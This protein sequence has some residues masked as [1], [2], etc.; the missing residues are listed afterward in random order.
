[1]K[2][3]L[4][5]FFSLCALVYAQNV[6]EISRQADEHMLQGE[7]TAAAELLEKGI[8]D[9]PDSADLLATYGMCLSKQA[10]S[11]TMMKAGML[12]EKAFKQFDAAL[13]LA[14]EHMNATLYRGILSIQVPSFMGKLH[15]GIRDLE[16]IRSKYGANPALYV[17]SN[18]YLGIGYQKNEEPAKAV[19]AFH[20]IL[21]YA[22]DSQYY[23]DAKQRYETLA[24][25][26]N[27]NS[28]IDHQTLGMR[29]MENGDCDT[30][31]EHLR[32]A[33]RMHPENLAL[34]L[35]FA[36]ALGEL[37]QQGY[38]ETIG[39]DVTARA[40]IAHEIHDVLTH[41]V[42]LAPQDEEIRFLRGSVAVNLPFFVNSLQ[43]GIEDLEYLSQEAQSAEIRAKAAFLLKQANDRKKVDELAEEGYMAQSDAEKQQLLAQ[44]II[45]DSPLQQK[46]PDA[47]CLQVDLTIGYRDQIAPQ[48]AVWVEDIDGNYLAT[49]YVSGFAAKVKE[50]QVHLPRW[51]KSSQ[52]AGIDAVTSASIDCGSHR[53][54]WD[55][56][57]PAGKL[58]TQTSFVLKSEICHWPHVQYTQQSL[59]IDLTSS[60][61]FT[62]TGDGFLLPR[63][64]AVYITNK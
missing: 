34:N 23:E 54:F 6:E 37:A 28:Q 63:I 25:N 59:S 27:R 13:Q 43:T 5:M 38:D 3:V 41:C 49:L 62:S 45:T 9:N 1:M 53:L 57:D 55:F 12:S 52:F 35:N 26:T 24:E 20:Y 2:K 32:Q 46:K 10:G 58:F 31:V 36:R 33:S 7:Y 19:E 4:I 21:L 39:D 22:R 30:A 8:R 47:D 15:Q 29:A 50:K 56:T 48:M 17:T 18:Y 64:D 44:F 51:A 60:S 40:G 42:A 16:N 14:P 61:R 11:A